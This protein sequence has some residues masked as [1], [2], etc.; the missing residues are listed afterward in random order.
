MKHHSLHKGA[1]IARRAA[2]DIQGSYN[3]AAAPGTSGLTS[4]P[5]TM[6]GVGQQP[7]DGG[8]MPSPPPGQIPG[9]D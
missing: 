8:E 4:G 7:Q 6:G 5:P 2:A 9:V 3:A 1:H